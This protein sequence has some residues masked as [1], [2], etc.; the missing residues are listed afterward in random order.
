MSLPRRLMKPALVAG[1][2][3]ATRKVVDRRRDRSIAGKR[4]LIT[5]GSR[6]LG[7]A[8]ARQLLD[9][10]CRVA[11]CARDQSELDAARRELQGRAGRDAVVAIQC[12][13]TDRPQVDDMVEEVTARFGGIDI[14]VNNAG[15]IVVGPAQVATEKDIRRSL[16]LMLWHLVHTTFAVVPEMRKRGDGQIVNITSFGG[17]L[18]I[19]HMM[20]YTT[21]KFAA[22]GFS[23]SLAVELAK[24]GITVTTVCPGEMQTGSHTKA[25]FK[26]KRDE[27]YRWF[28]LG[29]SA[30][31][32]MSP[33]RAARRIVTAIRRRET[34]VTFPW[35]VR[36]AVA[37]NGLAP[38]WTAAALRL[39]DKA[40]PSHEGADTG[41]ET[42]AQVDERKRGAVWEAATS[43]GREATEQYHNEEPGPDVAVTTPVDGL[44]EE[45][46]LGEG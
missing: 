6:G 14:L 4:V 13:V 7:L 9:E 44:T 10:G 29:A 16:D 5:G 31:W 27:E 36:T 17:K 19:P 24:D 41:I 26:G 8:L 22:V 33:D 20:P 25:L 30:P 45:R 43:L 42:G 37:V 46:T 34:D 21:A 12:D 1:T 23:S 38:N 11:I 18:S 40:L 35:T 39:M 28:A 3:I 32:T 15:L 2:A